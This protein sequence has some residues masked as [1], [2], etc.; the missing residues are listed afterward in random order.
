MHTRTHL[1]PEEVPIFHDLQKLITQRN[2]HER[3]ATSPSS[4]PSNS[5]ISFQEDEVQK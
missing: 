5:I 2:I 4:N 3:K 1:D